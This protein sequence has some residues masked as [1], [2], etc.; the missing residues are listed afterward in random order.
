MKTYYIR[1][2]GCKVNQYETQ[3][4]S[5]KLKKD[6]LI[7]V[8]KPEEADL[9]IFNSCTVTA[10]A[11]KECEYM[12][13]KASKMRNI[14]KIVLTGCLAVNKK[15]SLAEKFP[16]MEIQTDKSALF[17]DPQKQTIENF[18][19]RSRAFVK[20]QD[21][22]DSFCSYCIVP[23]VR[24]RL[25]SKPAE[26]VA[27]EIKKLVQNGYCEIVLTGIHIGKYENGLSFLMQEILKIPL[28]F[29]VRISSVEMNEIDDRLIEL[30][31]DR[32]DKICRHL[33]IPLQSGSDEVLKRMNR[34]YLT[35][36]FEKK[37]GKIM[38]ALPDAAVTSDIITGFPGETGKHHGQTCEFIRK[39][40]FSGFHIF[41]YSDRAGTKASSF[42]E[43]TSP[44]DIKKRSND[45]FE[46]DKEKRK[47]FIGKNEGKKR[48]AVSIGKSKALT[49]NYIK[50][51]NARTEKGIFEVAVSS[52]NSEI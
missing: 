3:L 19:K 17:S 39:S 42:G 28:C 31:I 38:S 13:R 10:E 26:T 45:L 2:F 46:I 33:H 22:C 6:G 27:E 48:K 30:M 15:D 50:V 36:D 18:E 23:Y 14:K 12:L 40:P 29:R 47:A 11:D 8:I 9:V 25:W 16:E 44:E 52:Q 37:I 51:K 35:K 32:P 34:H 7:R 1:T 24:K 21:G 5:D 41:R 20:I 4:I 43:K 49:D